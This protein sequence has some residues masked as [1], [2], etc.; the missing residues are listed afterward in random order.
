MSD[1]G[2][3]QEVWH[4][5]RG[6]RLAT[7]ASVDVHGMHEITFCLTCRIIIHRIETP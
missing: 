1:G 6:H 2:Y 5:L 4:W 7:H 3:L